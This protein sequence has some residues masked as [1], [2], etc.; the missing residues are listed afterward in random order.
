MQDQ[1]VNSAVVPAPAVEAAPAVAAPT[2]GETLVFN[3]TALAEEIQADITKFFD[4]GQKAP[5]RRL[6]KNLSL[7]RQFAKD[8]RKEISE[9]KNER[10][11]TA[12]QSEQP[13]Q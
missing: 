8:L 2:R 7:M 10:A 6:R 11:A 5:A 12:A 1:T 13:A 3:F 4:K 9:T